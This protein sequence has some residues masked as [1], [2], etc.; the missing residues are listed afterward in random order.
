[1]K[2]SEVMTRDVATVRPD[3]T[4]RLWERLYQFGYDLPIAPIARSMAS[5]S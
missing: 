2:V 1:M 3:Q 4:A 5:E